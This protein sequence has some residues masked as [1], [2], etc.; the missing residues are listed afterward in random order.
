MAGTRNGSPAEQGM[1]WRDGAGR[2]STRPPALR[3]C[4]FAL[5]GAHFGAFLRFLIAVGL[6]VQVDD[7]GVVDEPVDER[8]NACRIREHVIPLG[9]WLVGGDDGAFGLVAPADEFEEQIRCPV[10]IGQISHLVDDQ[11]RRPGVPAQPVFESDGAVDGGEFAEQLSGAGEDGSV[12]LDH[13][14]MRDVLGDHGFADAV[15]PSENGI[16][17]LAD[18]VEGH[19]FLD[20]SAVAL[21]RPVPVEVAQGLEPADAGSPEAAL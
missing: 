18:E 11:Q 16:G 9:E 2:L 13:S 8:D 10:G 3:F 15:W 14:L 6:T 12:A 7:F 19:E 4:S 20:S 21:Y 1:T 17:V 5:F